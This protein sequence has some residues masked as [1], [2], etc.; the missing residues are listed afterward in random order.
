VR[1]GRYRERWPAL[2]AGLGAVLIGAALTLKPFSSLSAL[3]ALVAASLAWIGV[4]ELIRSRGATRPWPARLAAALLLAGALL[5][6]LLPGRTV[7]LIAVVAGLALLLSGCSLVLAALGGESE[8]RSAA[9]I[10]GLASVI[11]GV[12]ALAWRDVTVLLIALLVGPVTVL[13]GLIQLDRALR[14]RRPARA[15]TA[16]RRPRRLARLAG[17]SASLLLALALL[18]LSAALHAGAPPV[19]GFYN[20]PAKLPSA[21]GR[22]L[23]S[24]PF[25]R[26]IPPSAQAWRILYTS[27]ASNGRIVAASALVVA[28]R[29]R[30]G[31]RPVILWTHGTT[32]VAQ[33]CAPSL[34]PVPFSG[35][36]GNL[37]GQAVQRGWV[38]VAPDYQGMGVR[39]PPSYLLGVPEAR[40]ALDAVRAARHVHALE[41][42][43]ET[44]AWGHSQGGGAALWVG[45][46]ARRYA[47]DVPLAGVAAIA[48]ASDLVALAEHLSGPFA[49]LLA[50]Y[51]LGAYSHA[52]SDISLSAFVR[53]TA[54]AIV[55]A[56]LARCTDEPATL[57][58]VASL[59]L[60][61]QSPFS[62]NLGG[63]PLRAR[64]RQNSP[65]QPFAVPT[66]IGQGLSDQV[67]DPA[68]QSRFV[69]QLCSAGQRIDYRTYPG[70]DHLGV[71]EEGSPLVPDL[72]S[73]TEAR[74]RGAPAP[75]NCAAARAR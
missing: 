42:A 54:L 14:G 2:L 75:S 8:E 38:V 28:P 11:F 68:V 72:L 45:I 40:S 71:I 33:A 19:Q 26:T 17:A 70:R 5:A 29:E 18:A 43:T 37:I 44:V 32:G 39:G 7:S 10:G 41:L 35:G 67:V 55:D 21:P 74:L 64:L 36:V 9:I 63:E 57:V 3:A 56:I 1:A 48:P 25:T 13:F 12:L 65:A 24:E 23:H 20:A 73:W 59:L 6:L 47:P 15:A 4:V 66:F 52:Y 51:V 62:K 34:L 46:E 27:T 61:G 30:S 60:A 69:A 31:P 50:S 49:T 16:S 58:S 22:L 53:P